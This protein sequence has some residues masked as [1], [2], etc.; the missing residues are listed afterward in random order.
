MGAHVLRK[1]FLGAMAD[2]Q[3][4]QVHSYC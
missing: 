3:T 1:A 2:I 4:A